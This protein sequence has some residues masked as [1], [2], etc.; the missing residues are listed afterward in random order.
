MKTKLLILTAAVAVAGAIAAKA[1]T[2]YSVN[3]VGYVNV[4]LYPGYNLVAN[5][6]NTTNNTIG[7]LLANVPRGT[8]LYKYNNATGLYATYAFE[9]DDDGILGWQPNGNATLNPGEGAFIRN[10]T[11]T[12]LIITFV[13]EVLQGVLTNTLPTGYSIRSSMVPQTGQVD[14]ILQ[15]PSNSGDLIYKFNPT[16]GRY[17]T[18]S[19]EEDDYGILGWQPQSPVINVGEAFFIRRLS[20]GEWIRNF[21][22][23]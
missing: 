16:M 4:T 13:G 18:F 11:G 23:Q 3:V 9:E 19:Y 22:V 17:D 12:N 14:S 1:Q 21:I 7:S 15:M 5:P 10:T 20:A 6:L 2:V 8:M